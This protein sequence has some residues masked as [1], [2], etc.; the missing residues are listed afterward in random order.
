MAPYVIQWTRFCFTH[1]NYKTEDIDYLKHVV[2][3][4][5]TWMIV[6]KETCPTTGTPHLQGFVYLKKKMSENKIK[7]SIM[8]FPSGK[9]AVCIPAKG[10]NQ[11]QKAYCSKEG[12]FFEIGEQPRDA[13]EAGAEASTSRWDRI[14]VLAQTNNNYNTFFDAVNDEFPDVALNM[15]DKLPKYY[16]QN[17]KS[18]IP[19]KLD[20]VAEW[21]MGP[22]GT[23]KS[24]AA[25]EENPDAYV[26]CATGKFFDGYDGEDCIILED[27]DQYSL[28][29][30]MPIFKQL[31]DQYQLRVEIKGTTKLIRPKKI[32][33]TSNYSISHLFPEPT[34]CAAVTRRFT[35][36]KFLTPYVPDEPES[37]PADEGVPSDEDEILPVNNPAP[38][39]VP[40][41]PFDAGFA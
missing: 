25:R 34:M 32:V 10:N 3:P 13:G 33:V 4:L 40:L 31:T 24:Y 16:E 41:N 8:R 22:P 28:K 9:M 15:V 20:V 7:K 1:C 12:D 29:D 19:K 11:S 17:N 18:K 2:G 39:T 38:A 5:C 37:D 26:K 23:G 14:R 35:V 6:G 30:I 36:R 27:L 21:M